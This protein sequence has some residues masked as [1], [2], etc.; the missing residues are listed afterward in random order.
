MDER[1]PRRLDQLGVKHKRGS[2]GTRTNSLLTMD[3]P[4]SRRDIHPTPI[5]QFRQESVSYEE[6]GHGVNSD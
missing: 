2:I 1:Q 6:G 3:L 4:S 5:T